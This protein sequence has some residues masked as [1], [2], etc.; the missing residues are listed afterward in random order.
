MT[1][2]QEFLIKSGIHNFVS[3]QHTGPA[4]IF[5]IKLCTQHKMARHAQMLIKN[6]YG[7]ATDIRFE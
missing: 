6:A 3:C 5:S 7:D 2:T 1:Q 4:P